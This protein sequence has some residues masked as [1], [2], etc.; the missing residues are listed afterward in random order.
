MIFPDVMIDIE[1]M[2]PEPCTTAAI[3]SIGAV[4]F[5]AARRIDAAD[6]F[7]ANILFTDPDLQRF[8]FDGGTV[9]WWM[10]QSAEAKQAL[11]E[12][13]PIKL[14]RALH[15]F[16]EWLIPRLQFGEGSTRRIWG[17]A[18]FDQ[19]N[20]KNAFRV[21]NMP[22]PWLRGD[23]MCYRT[24]RRLFDPDRLLVKRDESGQHDALADAVAQ[25]RHLQGLGLIWPPLK[26]VQP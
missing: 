6:L 2:A 22:L 3:I 20:V 12:P 5:D 7:K 14:R 16:S 23:E 21:M 15:D 13:A 10:G 19:V 26:L 4:A 1:T 11:V 18:G 8:T 9:Q 17:V 25:A 24:M